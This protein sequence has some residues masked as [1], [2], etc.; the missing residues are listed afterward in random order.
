M[1]TKKELKKAL[2]IIAPA[3]SQKAIPAFRCAFF[4]R[5]Y[6]CSYDDELFIKVPIAFDVIGGLDATALKKWLDSDIGDDVVPTPSG[7]ESNGS[8]LKLPRISIDDLLFNG[9]EIT[10]GRSFLFDVA[11][12][13]VP[14]K[15]VF[16]CLGVDSL[17][18][19]RRGV[20]LAS[21]Q[22]KNVACLYST[23]NAVLA[24]HTISCHGDNAEVILG[25]R[26]IETLISIEKTNTFTELLVYDTWAL[27]KFSSGIELWGRCYGDVDVDLFRNV[28]V[29]YEGLDAFRVPENFLPIVHRCAKVLPSVP[30]M[31]AT[32]PGELKVLATLDDIE[33]EESIS[34]S[35]DNHS[36]TYVNSKRLYE[37]LM[38][39][40]ENKF[41]S[42]W[43][44]CVV[45]E[46]SNG[47]ETG[48]I[49]VSS[50]PGL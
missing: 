46:A 39:P 20:T 36:L 12:N 35:F 15:F 25:P 27:A 6:V 5:N 7:V 9:E 11:P 4:N 17:W 50:E 10:T 32:A 45:I 24:N 33:I 30:M 16:C 23:N 22:L 21:F 48:M 34:C 29:R 1:V 18:P 41:M 42:I 47:D 14:F 49:C 26:F 13:I 2:R 31:L 44:D 37:A 28:F 3:I 43:S 8:S 38:A 19:S 40:N